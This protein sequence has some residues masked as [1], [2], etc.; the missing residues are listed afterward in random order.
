LLEQAVRSQDIT[1]GGLADAKLPGDLRD[2]HP[3]PLL[4]N[5]DAIVLT[6][7]PFGLGTSLGGFL[8]FAAATF[9]GLG[10]LDLE[11]VVVLFFVL[12]LLVCLEPFLVDEVVL[13][14]S[15]EVLIYTIKETKSNQLL[16]CDGHEVKLTY[17]PDC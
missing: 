2:R 5:D 13:E 6:M 9:G 15:R 11:G 12:D 17:C 1:D 3:L 7:P 16:G 10:N 8:R 14:A 4:G